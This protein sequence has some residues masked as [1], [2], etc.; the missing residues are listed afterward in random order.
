MLPGQTVVLPVIG[1]TKGIL[2]TL[3]LNT[4]AMDEPQELFA[5]TEITSDKLNETLNI[6][7]LPVAPLFNADQ[8]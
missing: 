3:T 6:S 5:V 7:P 2:F 1:L 4:E 8:L